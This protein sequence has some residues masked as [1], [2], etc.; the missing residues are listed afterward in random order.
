MKMRLVFAL[1]LVTTDSF[2]FAA[3]VPVWKGTWKISYLV[4]ST[5]YSRTI[6]LI[7]GTDLSIYGTDEYGDG[8]SG[9]RVGNQVCVAEIWNGYNYFL[10][11]GASD[12]W[13]FDIVKKSAHNIF[14][15]TGDTQALLTLTFPS[16]M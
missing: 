6:R 15:T 8:I 5:A 7:G 2:A 3:S 4:G 13:C 1:I 12:S 9:S 16:I 11:F 14:S 10:G